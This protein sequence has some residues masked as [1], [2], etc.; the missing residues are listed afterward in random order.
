MANIIDK[1]KY[2]HYDKHPKNDDADN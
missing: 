1:S 2:R